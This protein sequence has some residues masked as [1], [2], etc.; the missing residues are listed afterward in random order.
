MGKNYNY[1]EG[2]SFPI[3]IN[4]HRL[5]TPKLPNLD[6]FSENFQ[7]GAFPIQNISLKNFATINGN[8]VTNFQ[9]KAQHSFPTQGWA[10][11]V[12]GRLVFFRKF[13]QI[14]ELFLDAQIFSGYISQKYTLAI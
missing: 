6:E 4:S 7:K 3:Q 5:G 9:Q 11:G 13:I 10:G 1:L 12:K 2:V 14:W 8:L